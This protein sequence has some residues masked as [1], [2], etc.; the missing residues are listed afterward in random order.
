MKELEN[1]KI[2]IFIMKIFLGTKVIENVISR[3]CQ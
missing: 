2:I 3:L 1:I